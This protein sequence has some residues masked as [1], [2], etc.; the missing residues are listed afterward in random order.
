[1]RYRSQLPLEVRQEMTAR[2]RAEPSTAPAPSTSKVVVDGEE[3]TIVLD[4][5]D[6]N[7]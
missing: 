4:Q 7:N 5:P 2:V 6:C 3:P 1:M